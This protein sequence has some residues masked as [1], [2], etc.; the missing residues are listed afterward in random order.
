MPTVFINREQASDI[1]VRFLYEEDAY[2]FAVELVG[3]VSAISLSDIGDTYKIYMGSSY[4]PVY[5]IDGFFVP[6]VKNPHGV[7]VVDQFDALR[8]GPDKE[9][10]GFRPGSDEPWIKDYNIDYLSDNE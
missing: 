9:P 5:L 7:I 1:L 3:G 2:N 4:C 10:G 6:T 8:L